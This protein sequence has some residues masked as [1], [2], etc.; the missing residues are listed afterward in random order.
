MH[1]TMAVLPD[2][3]L[4]DQAFLPR[5]LREWTC[6]GLLINYNKR[7]P[8]RMIDL[9]EEYHLPS[10]WLNCKRDCDCVYPDDLAAGREAAQRLL[11][12]GHRRVAYVSY[13]YKVEDAHYSE[14]DRRDG[15]LQA[16][17]EAG[18]PCQA[19]DRYADGLDK[20]GGPAG[21]EHRTDVWRRVL[22]R[23]ERPTGV[24]AYGASTLRHVLR[25]A[26]DVGLRVPRDLSVVTFGGAPLSL[27]RQIAT[28]VIP[29]AE[30]G[31][32]GVEMLLAKIAAPGEALAPRVVA[33]EFRPGE[34]IG[35]PQAGGSM[36]TT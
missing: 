9:L 23:A 10:I 15:Y 8:Q 28:V 4:T 14:L 32:V 27:V 34:T 30:V 16:M 11:A 19:H 21:L 7:I 3:A 24:V 31:R 26:E 13:S 5:I 33:T 12:A 20:Q 25:A 29:E 18:L 22:A 6:D 35:P 17:R 36:S 1:L 2:E